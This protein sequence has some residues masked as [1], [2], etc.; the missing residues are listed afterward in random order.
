MNFP[1]EE[2]RLLAAVATGDRR[3]FTQLYSTYLHGLQRYIFLFTRSEETAQELAQQVFIAIWERRAQLPAIASFRQYLYRAAKN[4][5]YDEVRQQ[6]RQLSAYAEVHAAA[7][8]CGQP[9]DQALINQQ[10]HEQAQALIRQLPTKRRQIFLLRTQEELSLDEIAQRLDIS[11]SV[12]KKQL[13]AAIDYVK[14]NLLLHSDAVVQLAIC[15]LLPSV[16]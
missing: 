8:P 3:A 14:K 13:Y 6:Q 1:H 11:K 16:F 9:A 4:L 7:T 15:G 2:S 12:V 5:V 10:Y